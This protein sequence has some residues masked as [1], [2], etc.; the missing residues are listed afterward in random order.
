[1]IEVDGVS[2]MVK[3]PAENTEDMRTS[4]NEYCS[5]NNVTN[6]KNELVYIE[7]NM[8]SP[9]YLLLWALGYLVTVVQ[10]MVWSVGKA[11]NV[12]SSSENQL[13]NIADMANIKRGKASVTTFDVYVRAAQAG[14]TN[15]DESS[16]GTCTITS[17]DTITY[18]GVIYAPALHPSVTLQAG[19]S[20]Y[21]TMVA[22]TSGAYAI[23]EDSISGFDEG[24]NN[25]GTF[26]QYASVPGHEQETIASLRERIQRKQ[27]SG[28]TL[29]AAMDAIRE[30]EGVTTCSIYQNPSPT[31]SR[32][33]GIDGIMVPPRHTM[34][35]VQGYNAN[36]AR[37]YFEHLA[38]PSI[39]PL[40]D[41]QYSDFAYSKTFIPA[42]R[43][44][45]VQ[46]Y[47]THAGQALPVAIIKP[48]QEQVL[49]KVFINQSVVGSVE[50]AM[51]DAVCQ[52]ASKIT[53][54]QDLTSAM[55]LSQLADFSSY[56]LQGALV[57]KS[58]ASMGYIAHS[59]KDGLFAFSFDNI[60]IVMPEAIE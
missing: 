28:T 16:D 45:E 41:G 20:T 50:S 34:V 6:S 46:E 36:I 29:D 18:N 35:L 58:E 19:E 38:A 60:T 44:L 14:E 52:L 21:I 32:Q 25:I 43:L 9:V 55:V 15:Y 11:H 54:G 56:E 12:Q 10:K 37:T 23:S 59:E 40:T 57:G 26:K 5:N 8:A 39:L 4:I 49:V 24:I 30:L 3:T 31:D 17:E 1:M 22:T 48:K 51:K 27:T 42:D 53:A 2:F 47:V 13:L 7:Q 33:I